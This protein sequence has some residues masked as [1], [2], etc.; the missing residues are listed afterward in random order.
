[1]IINIAQVMMLKEDLKIT[2]YLLDVPNNNTA[3]YEIMMKALKVIL[4]KKKY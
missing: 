4:L 1:M 3:L 2:C